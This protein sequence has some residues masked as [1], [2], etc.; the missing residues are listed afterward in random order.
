[1]SAAP[2]ARDLSSHAI[3][4]NTSFDG[5]GNLRIKARPAAMGIKFILRTE[6]RCTTLPAHV[7]TLIAR[8]NVLPRKGRLGTLINNDVLLL[9][10]EWLHS[11][12]QK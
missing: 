7:Y 3:R 5:A 12:T 8:I 1:M 11:I 2:P 9:V 6:K 4:I 10:G